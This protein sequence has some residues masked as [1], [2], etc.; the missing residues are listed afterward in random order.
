M[1]TQEEGCTCS[2]S[3][4]I[5]GT[6]V[7]K[8]EGDLQNILQ[9]IEKNR[10]KLHPYVTEDSLRKFKIQNYEILRSSVFFQKY[11]KGKKFL[12]ISSFGLKLYFY[13]TNQVKA[14]DSGL[15]YCKQS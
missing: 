12:T 10:K 15:S 3:A 8:D 5:L 6:I 9:G 7:T 4:E 13:F 1:I 11:S 14:G 2:F